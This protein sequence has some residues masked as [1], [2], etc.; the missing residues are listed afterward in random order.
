[1]TPAP[2]GLI[3]GVDI[4]RDVECTLRDG[5]VLR[6]DVY[7]PADQHHE[8][9][10]L[11]LRI[12]Y[13]KAVAQ[14]IVYHHP[15]WYARQGYVV[16]VQDTRGRFS[17]GGDFNPLRTEA[18]D[19]A[20]A[21]GWAAG[22]AGSTGKVGMYGFSYAGAT[23][24]LAATE[25]PPALACCAPGFTSSDY[26]ADWT[27]EGGALNLAFIVS[28]TMQLLAI[29][30]A[31]RRGRPDVAELVAR[32]VGDIPALYSE[33]PLSAFSPLHGTGVAPFFFDWLAHDTRDEYWQQISL[34]HRFDAI[35]VPC[36][37]FGG[38][39][40]VF[41]TG[42][43]RNYT[44][45]AAA[46]DRRDGPGR[47]RLI[48]G[49]WLHLPWGP[50][51]GTADFGAEA[52]NRL[53]EA[54][55]AWFDRWLKG[56]VPQ[57][58]DAP[59]QLFVMGRDSWRTADSWPPRDCED[60]DWFLH[61]DG[62]ANSLS[63]TGSLTREVPGDELPDV[64]VYAPGNPAPSAGG[65][66]CCDATV[67]PMGVACQQGVEVRNDVLLYTTDPLQE[68]MEVTGDVRFV[69]HA[70][71]SAVD[72]DWVVR[73]TDVDKSGTSVN[74]CQGILRARFR[75]GLADPREVTPG[76]CY[77]YTVSLGPTSWEFGVGHRLRVQVTS[78]DFPAHDINSNTGK[79][80]GEVGPLDGIVATQ[81]VHHDGR[82][83]SRVILPVALSRGSGEQR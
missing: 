50:H 24:L 40:D 77:E 45:L 80:T 33:R 21:I 34:E 28:W 14:S 19:G 13:D 58:A 36:L 83:P 10:V 69:L 79:S 76:K 16:A 42:T 15:S 81:V 47:H 26:Y 54:Q 73:L 17:S 57:E 71:T 72:T 20:D 43:V 30:D 64:F 55:L 11:L 78:S 27:Y 63:G 32:R 74:V 61:S 44:E 39:F 49:P 82:R 75:T 3:P 51:V 46:S 62:R 29:P 7:R 60:Q 52:K 56:A 70:A 18:E 2:A 6:A 41:A 12:P 4:E 67:T 23:Q 35:D 9:P 8:L 68:S 25:R 48:M 37:H 5:T 31:L 53:N 66:S 22:L 65:R 1:M 38:W 59:V